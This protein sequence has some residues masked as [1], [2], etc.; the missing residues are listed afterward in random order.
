MSTHK[1]SPDQLRSARWFAPDD[2]RSFGHRSRMNQIGYAVEEF[3][4]KPI[5]GIINTWSDFAQCHA[6][7]KHPRRR[8]EARRAAGRRLPRR[9]ACDLAVRE[10]G[11]TDHDAVSQFPRHGDRGTDPLPAGRRRRA[12]G[13]LRQDHARSDPRRDQRRRARHLHA[14]RP[15]AARQLARQEVSARA[16][17]P[18]KYWDERRAGK[19]H[20]PKTGARWKTASPAPTASA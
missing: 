2:I 15:H 11:Q 5:I 18:W 6:H 17:T 19:H 4:G 10:H 20:R 1:K 7:F 16:P 12:D 3:A 14:R 13:R 9:A 8:R